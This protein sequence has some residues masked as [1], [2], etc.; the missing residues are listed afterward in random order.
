MHPHHDRLRHASRVH[1]CA[2]YQDQ[3]QGCDVRAPVHTPDSRA[4]AV[5]AQALSRRRP[6][7]ANVFLGTRL[8]AIEAKGAI[9]IPQLPWLEQLEL[10]PALPMVSTN[11]IVRAAGSA[12]GG[13]PDFDL[14]WR[15]H[16]V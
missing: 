4:V 11:A 7:N 14:Q 15:N 16:R 3:R 12:D 13:F 8:H 9:E 5:R 2:E 10:T 6:Q 1:K